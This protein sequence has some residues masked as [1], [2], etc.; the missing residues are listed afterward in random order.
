[1][2]LGNWRGHPDHR[3]ARHNSPATR[4]LR[5]AGRVGQCFLGRNPMLRRHGWN[6]EILKTEPMSARGKDFSSTIGGGV[7]T[8]PRMFRPCIDLHEGKVKQIVGGT[9]GGDPGQLRTNFV[10][11]R[12]ASWYA[13]LYRRDG[14]KGGHV[15][16][17]GP[18]N[19]VEARAALQAYPG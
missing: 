8:V 7:T 6:R 16:M 3:R 19:E 9:L 18:G 11:D 4:S 10:S 13:D 5:G 12:S 1:V 2:W 14:L 17:L 15:V